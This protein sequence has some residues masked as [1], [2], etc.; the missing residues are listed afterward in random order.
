MREI[1]EESNLGQVL[2]VLREHKGQFVT[3]NEIRRAVRFTRTLYG[4]GSSTNRLRIQ[5][6]VAHLRRRDFEIERLADPVE[7][8]K[9]VAYRLVE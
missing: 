1:D 3:I 6:A 4:S 7:H 8:R 2:R 5:S 9:I